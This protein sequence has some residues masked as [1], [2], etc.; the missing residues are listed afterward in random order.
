MYSLRKGHSGLK[1]L[2]DLEP[3]MHYRSFNM[4]YLPH[5]NAN[6]Y[7]VRLIFETLPLLSLYSRPPSP[8][9]DRRGH[10]N[11]AG[12]SYLS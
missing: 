7:E 9:I 5:I 6:G 2:E 11:T 12:L 1:D 10:V 4:S 3:G 8:N